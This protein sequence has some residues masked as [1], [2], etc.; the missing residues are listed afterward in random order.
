MPPST[1]HRVGG[2]VYV[3]GRHDFHIDDVFTSDDS[4]VYVG[5]L[6]GVHKATVVSDHV[7]PHRHSEAR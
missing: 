1:L 7:T 2:V 5:R 4:V 6:G 3:F